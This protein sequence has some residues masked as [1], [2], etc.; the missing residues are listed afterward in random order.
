MQAKS[1]GDAQAVWFFVSPELVEYRYDEINGVFPELIV[2]GG[3]SESMQILNIPY[4]LNGWY[5]FCRFTNAFG[6][7]DSQ[8]A[9]INVYPD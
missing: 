1:I 6:S 4:E 9:Q 7:G 5:V 2:R 3:G 8:P